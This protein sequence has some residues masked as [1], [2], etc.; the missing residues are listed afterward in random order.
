MKVALVFLFVALGAKLNAKEII[1]LGNASR[2]VQTPDSCL[3]GSGTCAFKT[4]PE[5]KYKIK[6]G[7]NEIVLDENTT[8]IR[9]SKNKITLVTGQI[10]VRAQDEIQIQTEYGTATAFEGNFLAKNRDK[11]MELKAIDSDLMLTP[12]M[13]SKS[14]KLEAGEQNWLGP[15]DESRVA[16]S[17]VPLPIRPSELVVNWSRLYTGTKAD[18]E[19][20]F[21]NFFSLWSSA[22]ERLAKLHSDITARQIASIESEIVRKKRLK[23]NQDLET[24][25][26]KAWFRQK[27]LA[28]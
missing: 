3:V 26:I 2:V 5:E 12:K 25:R 1:T 4:G 23:E 21:K 24:R 14:L 16:S 27:S 18:F 28:D 19:K 10:W 17:G 22:S 6:L 8:L 15:I 9:Q 13:S 20:D 7:T 11:K